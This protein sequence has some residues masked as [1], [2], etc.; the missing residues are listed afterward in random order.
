MAKLPGGK[1]SRQARKSLR[2]S[3]R[4]GMIGMLLSVVWLVVAL[5]LKILD[6]RKK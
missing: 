2:L 6:W 5:V 4:L 1:R 3:A